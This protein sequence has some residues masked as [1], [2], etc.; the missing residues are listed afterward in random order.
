MRQLTVNI[1]QNMKQKSKVQCTFK[2]NTNDFCLQ[3]NYMIF[4][5]IFKERKLLVK[6]QEQKR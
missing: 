4:I 3:F 1:A 2:Q 5:Q 6:T